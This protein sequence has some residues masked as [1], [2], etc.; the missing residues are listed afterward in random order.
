[1][2]LRN[3]ISLTVPDLKS[4]MFIKILWIL[5]TAMNLA[6]PHA[7][8][9][10]ETPQARKH[11]QNALQFAAKSLWRP[12]I[13]ELNRALQYE[14]RN[15]EIL[16]ESGI[17]WGELKEWKKATDALRKAVEL[18]PKSARAHYNLAVTLDRANPG[19]GAGSGEYR[20]ALELDPKYVDA[21]INLAADIGDQDPKEARKLLERALQLEPKSANAWFNLGLLLGKEGD[22][23]AAVQKFQ[24]AIALDPTALEP[25]RHLVYALN[26]LQRRNAVIEQC[27]EILKCDPNDWQMRYTL[28]RAL[29]RTGRDKEGRREVEK[30]SET[31]RA[32]ERQ[33]EAEKLVK[34][35]VTNFTHGQTAEATNDARAALQ[36][37]NSSAEAHM[38]LGMALA[39][40]GSPQEGINEL[41]KSIEL[42]PSNA[43]GH[44]NLG[45]VLL[46]LG[47]EP[48]AKTEFERT[49]E[50]DPYLPEAHNNLGLILS[51]NNQ[52]Q[53][54]CEHFRLAS[55]LDPQYLEAPF[56]LGLALR[57]MNRL[58]EALQAFRQAAEIAPEN[59]QV[60][61]ALGMTLQE[62]GDME[63]ARKALN[64]AAALQAGSHSVPNH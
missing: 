5:L 4:P 52:L 21:L 11:Y 43:K 64:R 33:E 48:K 45:T 51:R 36:L 63:G 30:S 7:L 28:G 56:N 22:Q 6:P 12:A 31:R 59:A 49:L 10:L 61:Y 41:N 53:Q 38:V 39:A 3:N 57:S 23:P 14:P 16:I 17:A 15:P 32:R 44:V 58:D 1:M 24:K 29:M 18:A 46:Q 27:R 2:G 25:R 47:E 34:Q 26:A 62:K 54:A 35:A 50:L 9:G 60:Q 8:K 55:E 19:F 13:L 37:N 40:S 20:K 42:D